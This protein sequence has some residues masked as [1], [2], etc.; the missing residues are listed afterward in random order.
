[1]EHPAITFSNGRF[2]SSAL[3]KGGFGAQG[4]GEGGGS[5]ALSAV[6]ID[7]AVQAKATLTE[8]SEPA[9]FQN[10]NRAESKR[11]LIPKPTIVKN[12]GPNQRQ[13]PQRAAGAS[14][15]HPIKKKKE[16]K[17]DPPEEPRPQGTEKF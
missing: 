4:A 13:L 9:H 12:T 8:P 7:W 3:E 16:K 14:N 1:M 15:T 5:P 17:I 6:K 2:G 11:K 10:L